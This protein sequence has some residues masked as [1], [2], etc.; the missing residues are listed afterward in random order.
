MP[1][2]SALRAASR[3]LVEVEVDGAFVVRVSEALVARWRLHT[4]RS[5]TESELESLCIAADADRALV[6]AYRLLA[7]RSR[8]VAEMRGRLL[9]KG[10]GERAVASALESL[11]A[12]GHLDDAAFVRS[13]VAAKRASAGWGERRI[14]QGLARLGVDERLI[15]TALSEAFPSESATLEEAVGILRK[16]G[17]LRPPL[18]ASRRRAYQLL[19]RRGFPAAVAYAAVRRWAAGEDACAD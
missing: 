3:G 13:Y 7:H 9:E 4:G 19:L 5:L 1:A 8:T 18:D 6:N 11:V 17:V 2:V 16:R 10:H 15:E 14:R 12:A